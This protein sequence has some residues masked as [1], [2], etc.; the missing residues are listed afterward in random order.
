MRGRGLCSCPGCRSGRYSPWI[1][2]HARRRLRRPSPAGL[3]TGRTSE[4]QPGSGRVPRAAR[5]PGCG[6][7]TS[8]SRAAR[9]P[10]YG[11][12]DGVVLADEVYKPGARVLPVVA[13][14]IRLPYVVCPLH[15]GGDVADGGV[16]PD[17]EALVL[18]SRLRHG[19]AP[20]D[21]PGDR[22]PFEPASDHAQRE[23]LHLGAPVF[24]AADP[25]L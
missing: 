21:V 23:V 16:E 17:V 12:E 3:K 6:W 18:E 1:G 14:E 9:R 10:H 7:W 13:P 4:G 24:L 2:T 20:E 22:A 5:R 25:L 15:R 11:V 19:D 8:A